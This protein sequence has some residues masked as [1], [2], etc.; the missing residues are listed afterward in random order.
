MSE[1]T[2]T[3]TRAELIEGAYE[4]AMSDLTVHR[5]ALRTC[6]RALRQVQPE[7]SGARRQIVEDVARLVD[8]V[9]FHDQPTPPDDALSVLRDLVA[10]EDEPHPN[11]HTSHECYVWQDDYRQRNTAAW[12]RA[13]A[14]VAEHPT[15]EET[16]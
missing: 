10:L 16:P 15:N 4:H 12:A 1:E 9:L 2:V 5:S 6:V 13:R 3:V 7:L 14:L 11:G 8:R